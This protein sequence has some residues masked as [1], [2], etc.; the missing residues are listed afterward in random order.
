MAL[1]SV[2]ACLAVAL[3]LAATGPAS[4]AE[5]SASGVGGTRAAAYSAYQTTLKP[6]LAVPIGW[7]GSTAGCVAG[8]PSAAAQSATLTAVNFYRSMVDLPAVAFDPSF[9]AQAQEAALMMYAQGDLSHAPGPSWACYSPAGS[10]GAGKSNLYLGLAGAK[11]VAGYM[12]DP[13]AGNEAV[14]HRRWILF[15][16]QSTMGSGS[17]CCSNALYVLGPQRAAGPFPPWVPWPPPGYVPLQVE[18]EGR[19][20]LS[21]SGPST[22][23]SNARVS[24]TSGGTSLPVTIQ[25]SSTGYG[26]PTLVWQLNPAYGTGRPDRAYEVSVTNIVQGGVAVSHRYTVTLFDGEINA[27]QTISFPAPAS[28]T[29]GDPAVT[30]TAT[31]TSGLP[32]AFTST[33]TSVCAT[34]GTNGATIT[35]VG[36]GTCSI[37]ADQPG[38]AIRNPAPAVVRSFTVAKKAITVKADDHTRP[39]RFANPSLTVTYTGLAYGQTL[40][41]SGISGAP[42]CTTTATPQ[43]PIGTYPVSCGT[44]T[45]ASGRYSFTFAPGI[46]TVRPPS[47]YWMVSAA[48]TVYPFGDA[49]QLGNGTNGAVDIEPTPSR[50]GYWV[51]TSSGAVSVHGDARSFGDRPPLSAGETVSALSATP[52]GDGYWLFTSRGRVLAFGLAPHLGDLAAF[53]LDGPVLD[54][55]ATPSGRG[56]YMVASDGG[57]FAFGDARFSGSM[58]GIR[59]DAPVMS[60]APDPDGDGYWLVASDGGVFAFG[61]PFVGSLGGVRLN[62]PISGMVASGGGYLMVG[63]DG[64]IFA[65][66]PGTRFEGSLGANPPPSPVVAVAAV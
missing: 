51:V 57:I 56:Y 3:S 64:G 19:W 47:G 48:G 15:P 63:E 65:F 21:A 23:F 24:V 33:T 59:L 11:A 2:V 25:P 34:S 44:G 37:R 53:R 4:S 13:G 39:V 8:S 9:S 58:G 50:A 54:S 12:D 28:R 30:A 31:A 1:V 17:T 41:T 18:P 45:L 6:A 55:T 22:D 46:L 27:D 32:V 60:L 35:L 40:A 52:S 66:G 20:S 5:V 14:G 16:P 42:S 61:A 7:S 49:R 10:T 43:S 36:A 38:D 26:S 62:R 29:Y